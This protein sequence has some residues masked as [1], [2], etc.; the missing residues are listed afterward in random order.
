MARAIVFELNEA[1][2][3][4]MERFIGA[5]PMFA[6]MR[7]EGAF[8][9][10]RI[11]GFDR[12][13]PR[14]WRSISPWI[15]WP[16]VYTGLSP[17]EHGIVAFGQDPASL[18]GRCVW[19]VLAKEGVRVGVMG[20]LLSYPPRKDAAFHLPETLADD[21][22]CVPE[23]ARP[24]QRF[25][26]ETSRN[27]S[28]H[29]SLKDG[30]KLALDLVRSVRSGVHPRTAA[31]TLAQLPVERLAGSHRRADRA[32]LQADLVIDAFESLAREHR[33]G[34]ACMHSNHVAFVQHRFWRAAEPHRFGAALSP[35]DARFFKTHEELA[36]WEA[37]F[38]R[39]IEDAFVRTDAMLARL[40]KL[41]D[42]DGVL[43]LAT[44]L[45]QRPFDPSRGEIFNP[46][47]RLSRADELLDA[48]GVPPRVI[49]HQMN[50]D[51]TLTFGDE[52]AAIAGER[53]CA[54]FEASGEKLFYVQRKGAQVFLEL[55]LHPRT[56]LTAQVSG[57]GRPLDHF[58]SLAPTPD[59]STAQHTDQ[60]FLLAWSPGG[61]VRA[62]AE[63]VDVTAIAPTLLSLYNIA[64]QPWMKDR[65]L[66][67]SAP[68]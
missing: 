43:V 28:E 52:A 14:N 23:R 30:L 65:Q 21:D 15:I 57:T 37:H 31:R 49:R 36:R 4:F 2:A 17:A 3:H 8:V 64:P 68:S 41:L 34:F 20:S 19:D 50:P 45:G 12:E 63:S 10:T 18:V 29:V 16:S 9:R 55:E 22:A 59:Q 40:A 7:R 33:P 61:R 62:L 58:I 53:A 24:L 13:S 48:A 26:V 54:A 46:V 47:V 56:S 25:L 67:F 42:P 32:H 39:A 66:A 6:R 11:P 1:D 51:L 5:L 60:G 44:A 35:T 38:S 27:Y